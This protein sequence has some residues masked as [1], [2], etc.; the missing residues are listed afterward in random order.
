MIIGAGSSTNEEENH[1]GETQGVHI[2][3][4]DTWTEEER[5]AA[6]AAALQGLMERGDKAVQRETGTKPQGPLRGS[7]KLGE[8]ATLDVWSD[9]ETF[10]QAVLSFA[11]AKFYL[12]FVGLLGA[13][14]R[15]FQARN[16]PGDY[17]FCRMVSDGIVVPLR[18]ADVRRDD[19]E[20]RFKASPVYKSRHYDTGIYSQ[21]FVVLGWQGRMLKNAMIV[22][23][24]DEFFV[25]LNPNTSTKPKAPDYKGVAKPAGAA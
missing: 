20:H 18:D 10:C 15:L 17:S 19:P 16:E 11:G 3:T 13:E 7:V 9:S 12:N 8:G 2:N 25:K 22:N 6:R 1:L 21:M 23:G 24:P 4:A 5:L 14:E